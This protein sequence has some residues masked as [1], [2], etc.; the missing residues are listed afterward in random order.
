MGVFPL[1]FPSPSDPETA[2]YSQTRLHSLRLAPAVRVVPAGRSSVR[3]Q[4]PGFWALPTPWTADKAAGRTAGRTAGRAEE[5]SPAACRTAGRAEE[6]RQID[7]IGLVDRI[8][9]I[10]R[11]VM[12]DRIG[13]V[14]RIVSIDTA[15]G[16]RIADTAAEAGSLAG[17]STPADSA[18]DNWAGSPAGNWRQ[19]W[20]A[21]PGPP[22]P[23]GTAWDWVRSARNNW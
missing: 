11:I 19:N 17:N 1:H 18:R 22:G 21:P 23:P 6:D 9:S 10:D 12:V 4:I 2:D 7:R 15:V 20:A 14:D 8:V 16:G 13:L 5:D 3:R